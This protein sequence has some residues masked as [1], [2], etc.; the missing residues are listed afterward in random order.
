MGYGSERCGQTADAPGLNAVAVSC[1][2]D[3]QHQSAIAGELTTFGVDPF[4]AATPTFGDHDR[5]R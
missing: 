2:T 3:Q 5:V 1:D 4:I